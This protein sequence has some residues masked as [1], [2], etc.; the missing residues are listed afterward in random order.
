LND[1]NVFR[2]TGTGNGNGQGEARPAKRRALDPADTATTNTAARA[3]EVKAA[4]EAREVEQEKWRNKWMKSFPT[5][6][7]H[8]E[9]EASEGS[10]KML[11]AR[12]IKMGAVCLSLFNQVRGIGGLMG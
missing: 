3:K 9:V 11:K 4:R 5:L 7:F 1:E 10:G 6:T 12:A 2:N 8:F